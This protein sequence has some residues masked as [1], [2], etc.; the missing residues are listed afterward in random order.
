MRLARPAQKHARYWQ[1]AQNQARYGCAA[2]GCCGDAPYEYPIRRVSTVFTW[3]ISR[4]EAIGL[5]GSPVSCPILRKAPVSKSL[6]RTPPVSKSF[7]RKNPAANAVLR[8][9]PATSS[10]ACAM[11]ALDTV[12]HTASRNAEEQLAHCRDARSSCVL[13]RERRPRPHLMQGA[14]AAFSRCASRRSEHVAC[15]TYSSSPFVSIT[16]LYQLKDF[17]L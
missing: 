4:R 10:A 14:G 3:A 15:Q 5:W 9:G 2:V 11:P 17:F 7:L 1:P 6:L 12:Q 13:R 16:C 8:S